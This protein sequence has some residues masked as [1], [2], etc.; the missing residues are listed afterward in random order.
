MKLFFHMVK[1]PKVDW[2]LT[3]KLLTLC[4]KVGYTAITISTQ[5]EIVPHSLYRGLGKFHQICAFPDIKDSSG[6]SAI[7]KI[8]QKIKVHTL[9]GNYQQ[10]QIK[11]GHK[12]V[13]GAYKL[14]NAKWEKII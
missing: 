14:I 5:D 2:L 11:H 1:A 6:S 7:W 9:I 12:L 8:V 10:I 4:K 3:K 13:E